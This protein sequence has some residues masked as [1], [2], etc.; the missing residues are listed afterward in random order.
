VRTVTP[1]RIRRSP[2]GASVLFTGS[3]P[4]V[5]RVEFEVRL[6]DQIPRVDFI[7]RLRKPAASSEI[8]EALYFA[9]PFRAAPP[10]FSYDRALGWVNPAHDMLPGS[11]PEWFVATN[12]VNVSGAGDSFTLATPDAPLVTF[13]DVV[14]CRWPRSF[15]PPARGTVFSYVYNNYWLTNFPAGQE[16]GDFEW[17]YSLTTAPT[18][19]A[20][21]GEEARHPFTAVIAPVATPS[22]AP[23]QID[24]THVRLVTLRRAPYGDGYLIRL[25][26]DSGLRGEAL[27]RLPGLK[28]HSA[29]LASTHGEPLLPLPLAGGAVRV[30]LSPYGQVTLLVR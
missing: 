26:E 5:P 9:F 16:G 27:V 11:A 2:A 3:S 13:G 29:H 6:W 14:R 4:G 19:R 15:S 25:A 30:P 22:P 1:P 24:S 8:A 23:I 18:A 7:A 17:R 12:A 20:R 10:S 28:A 21:I